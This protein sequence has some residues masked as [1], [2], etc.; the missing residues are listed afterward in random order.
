MS[1]IAGIDQKRYKLKKEYTVRDDA[2]ET[3]PYESGNII[4]IGPECFAMKDGS[5]LNWRGVNY[6]RQ[7][8]IKNPDPYN[9]YR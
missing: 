5:V 1:C 4:V 9:D 6:V 3:Y 8:P 7:E 2:H